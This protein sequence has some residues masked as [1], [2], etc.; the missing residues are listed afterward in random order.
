M[1]TQNLRLQEQLMNLQDEERAELARDLHDEVGPYLF[2]AG[3]DAASIQRLAVGQGGKEIAA[4][5]RAI[6]EA[7]SHVQRH[8]RAILARL[9]PV[10]AVELGLEHAIGQQVAFWRGRHPDIR[11]TVEVSAE[12]DALDDGLKE[13]TYRIVQESLSNAVRHGGPARVDI[14]LHPDDAG[15][16]LV[17]VTD[18]GAGE[19]RTGGG[20]GFGLIG[21]RE[22]VAALAGTLSAGALANGKGWKV[23]ARLPSRSRAGAVGVALPG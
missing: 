19:V 12:E 22:R 2:A 7:V 1:R 9:R 6:Q 13:A 10:R 5:A 14:A 3:V 18:D 16:L 11:F 20:T 15:G 4:Q 23:T 21:M 17:E 8:V